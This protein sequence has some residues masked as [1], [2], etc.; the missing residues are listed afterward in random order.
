MRP[1]S[2]FPAIA[3]RHRPPPADGFTV[4][5]SVRGEPCRYRIERHGPFVTVDLKGHLLGLFPASGLL[6]WLDDADP[7]PLAN[8]CTRFRQLGGGY[9]LSI[10]PV[11]TDLPLTWE[12]VNA[13][14]QLITGR[15]L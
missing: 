12:E 2:L 8:T 3:R 4:Q 13:L 14:R 15:E 6:I 10:A 5:V 9:T 7:R 11:F 1:R